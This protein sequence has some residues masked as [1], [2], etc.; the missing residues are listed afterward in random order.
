M[1]LAQLRSSERAIYFLVTGI[2][3]GCSI[4]F[5]VIKAGR[6]SCA[7]VMVYH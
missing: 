3:A 6:H 7:L 4:K 2:R 1:T 5:G